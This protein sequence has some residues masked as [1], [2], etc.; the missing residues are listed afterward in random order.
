MI[1]YCGL[2]L[3]AENDKHLYLD[4]VDIEH[5]EFGEISIWYDETSSSKLD[6]VT[7]AY[8]MKGV[9]FMYYGEDGE[10]TEVYGNGRL[11]VIKASKLTEVVVVDADDNELVYGKDF[12]FVDDVILFEDG[13][14]TFK[15]STASYS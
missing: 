9:S 13:D 4:V 2:A 6:G 11:D 15:L 3:K 14:E 10:E 8:R 12:T 7:R 5:P 1:M